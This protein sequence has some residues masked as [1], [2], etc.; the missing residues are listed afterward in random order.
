[1]N[2]ANAPFIVNCRC[3][4]IMCK[5]WRYPPASR[6]V[7]IGRV[8]AMVCVGCYVKILTKDKT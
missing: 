6:F 3:K 5:R 7:E 1:M 4:C 8:Y 2:L